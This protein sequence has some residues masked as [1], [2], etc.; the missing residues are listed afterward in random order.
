MKKLLLLFLAVAM[1]FGL[2]SQ[3]LFAAGPAGFGAALLSEKDIAP[4]GEADA[5]TGEGKPDNAADAEDGDAAAGERTQAEA[6]VSTSTDIADGDFIQVS[7]SGAVYRM[8][9]GAPIWVS[10]WSLFGGVQPYR[11]LSDAQFNALP[12]YPEPGTYISSVQTGR[13][14][15]VIEDGHLYCIGAWDDVGG[16]KSTVEV[17]QKGIE[18]SLNCSP[19]GT[20]DSLAGGVGTVRVSGWALDD[21]ALH[22]SLQIHVY[23]GGPYG[24][25]NADC[26]VME[27]PADEHR[28]DIGILYPGVGDYHGFD[29]AIMVPNIKSTLVYVYAINATGTAGAN[30]LLASET[31]F[32]SPPPPVISTTVLPG[33][34]VGKGYTQSLEARDVSGDSAGWRIAGGA[35][36]DG[37]SL[38]ESGV[39]SG[40]PEKNGTFKFAAEAWNNWGSDTKEFSLTISP[41]PA[42]PKITTAALPVGLLGTAYRQTLASKGGGTILWSL[43]GGAL[44]NGL[45]LS[46]NGAIAGTPGKTGTYRFAAKASNDGGSDAK[47]FVIVIAPQPAVPRISYTAQPAK[48]TTVT[49]GAITGHL[50]ASATVTTDAVLSYQ[51]YSNTQ[52]SNFGG[53]AISGATGAQWVIPRGLALGTY[54][55]YCEAGAAGAAPMLSDVAEVTVIA[56]AEMHLDKSYLVLRA[57]DAAQLSAYDSA[58]LDSPA[59]AKWATS[60]GSVARVDAGGRVTAVGEGSAV[61]S[62]HS[63]DNGVAAECR[64]DVTINA[65]ADEVTGVNLLQ[66]SVTCNVLSTHY[67]RV[68]IQL[69]LEQ[70]KP[71]AVNTSGMASA[72]SVRAFSVAAHGIDVNG[73]ALPDDPNGYFEVRVV[74]DRFVELRPT[75]ALAAA[76]K[77]KKLVTRLAV[78]VDG[79][80]LVTAKLSISITRT[81]PP[82]K[83]AKLSFNTFFPNTPLPVSISSTAGNITGIELAETND[84]RKVNYNAAAGTLTLVSGQKPKKLVFNVGVEGFTGTYPVAVAVSAAKKN[85]AVKLSAASVS[86]RRTATLRVTGNDLPRVDAITVENNELYSVSPPDANGYFTIR[87]TDVGDVTANAGLKLKLRFKDTD[88]TL[89]LK[90]NV[91]KPGAAKVTL[92]QKTLTLNMQLPGGDFAEFGYQISPVDAGT[93]DIVAPAEV[94]V[95]SHAVGQIRVSLTGAAL[96]GKSYKV[97][98]GSATLSV[99]TIDKSPSITLKAKGTLNVIDADSTV[100]LTP[101]FNNYS[102]RGERVSVDNPNFEI[103]GVNAKGAVTLRLKDAALKPR[104][105]QTLA[106]SYT[107]A[108]GAVVSKPVG[109][110]PKQLTPKFTLSAHQITLQKNDVYSEG[111]I[112]IAVKSPAGARIGRVE[113]NPKDKNQALYDL[114]KVQNG[115]YAIGYKGHVIGRVGKG[116]SIKLNVYFEGSETPASVTV[117]ISV[118]SA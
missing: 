108:R 29:Y 65:A 36:P 47:E 21:D 7:G 84:Y 42:P 17:D 45:S 109:I 57:G 96:A 55:Y 31:V 19:I 111:Q 89:S 73:A 72:Q 110:T 117:K 74:D 86:M 71:V 26:Y 70:N 68:P 37:L 5:L 52:N 23:I 85:P 24:S 38:S 112:G 56:G 69:V 101:V 10:N 64:V 25:P 49:R 20:V 34:V 30:T 53:T 48:T 13:A 92:A 114:R 43:D 116:A 93:P 41:A 106:L 54:Y 67:A 39:I 97:K 98:I 40:V 33:G 15:R 107:G 83:A 87:Y 76:A 27:S 80:I 82:L 51:W 91:K 99:K 6:A 32:I 11:S 58:A 77:V 95:T 14:Y 66:K 63:E 81:K 115:R 103:V 113:I 59:A 79:K 88:Q 102:Y 100:T 94:L 22:S 18:T 9:G 61:I 75:E 28:P 62:A 60:D 105:K 16:V 104:T 46:A 12:K 2:T 4:G 118:V 8:A 50:F 44:P 35:L 78:S 1:F 3:P 90:L